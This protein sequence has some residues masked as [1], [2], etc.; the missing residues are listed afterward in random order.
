MQ[1]SF[2][3]TYQGQNGQFIDWTASRR[4]YLLTFHVGREPLHTQDQNKAL[5]PQHY[6]T[7]CMQDEMMVL[8]VFEEVSQR[9]EGGRRIRRKMKNF[10]A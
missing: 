3:A 6:C 4:G 8:A 9:A 1:E 10:I 5:G 7:V 2:D